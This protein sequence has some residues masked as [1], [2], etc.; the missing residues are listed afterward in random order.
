MS[1]HVDAG[2]SMD[3]GRYVRIIQRRWR[4]IA[5]VTLLGL[6]MS[7]TYLAIAPRQYTASTLVNINIITSAPFNPGRATGD[8]VDA[9]TEI[10]TARSSGVV[11]SVADELGGDTT[12][13][14]VREGMEVTV[15]PD[16]TVVRISFTSDTERSA[17]EAADQIA[18][19]YLEYR[20]TQARDRLD[21]I[22]EQLSTRRASLR[23]QLVEVNRRVAEAGEGSQAAAQAESDRQVLSADLDALAGQINSLDGIDTQGGSVL[24]AAE[25][26]ALEQSPR[27]RFVLV[28]GVLG[29]FLLGLVAVF[30][31]NVL[32]R[33]VRDPYDIS[34]AGG[35]AVLTVLRSRTGTV[36]DDGGSDA[37]AIRSLRE[38][39]LATMPLDDPVLSVIEVNQ[40]NEQ[41]DVSVSLARAIAATGATVNLVVPAHSHSIVDAVRDSLGPV[42]LKE[43]NAWRRYR[44]PVVPG[45][46]LCVPSPNALR[47]ETPVDLVADLLKARASGGVMTL[48][49]L[50][51]TA[52]RSLRLAAG[53]LGHAV[54]LVVSEGETKIDQLARLADEL[55]AVGATVHGSVLVPKGR[56]TSIDPHRVSAEPTP[57]G[58][59]SAKAADV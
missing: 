18:E 33:R 20:S 15:L 42:E 25:D 52:S 17:V 57:G 4:I 43:E 35:G 44:G 38:R 19:A 7:V 11:A 39:L 47:G 40:G 26:V 27:K 24:T 1:E 53:R 37:D 48:L 41:L 14:T 10:Q 22:Q 12:S 51:P 13:A 5:G 8:L 29:G 50:P 30:V 56:R 59:R 46:T 23:E 49:A 6:V 54:V 58:R 3:L 45:L 16:A 9:Q 21:G 34:G 36:V 31:V 2:M 32:D 28:T 55:R